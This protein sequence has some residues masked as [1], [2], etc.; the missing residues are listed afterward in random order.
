MLGAH[1]GEAAQVAAY[2]YQ[3]VTLERAADMVHYSL[4]FGAGLGFV[5][6]AVVV[7]LVAVF[8]SWKG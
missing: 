2:H 7:A 4:I 3:F 1:A 8:V 6:G 5:A